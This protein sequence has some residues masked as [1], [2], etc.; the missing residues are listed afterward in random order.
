LSESFSLTAL[1]ESAILSRSASLLPAY[2]ARLSALSSR[3]PEC[4]SHH[5]QAAIN[6][7]SPSN[8][9]VS[10]RLPLSVPPAARALLLEQGGR[11][12]LWQ[13]PLQR[14]LGSYN[15]RLTAKPVWT[16]DPAV[17]GVRDS[18]LKL[19]GTAREE[20]RDTLSDD[21]AAA[22][23]ESEGLHTGDW[24]EIVILKHNVPAPSAPSSFPETLAAL[25][26]V[27]GV[28]AAKVSMVGPGTRIRPHTGPSNAR[29]RLHLTLDDGG[30]AANPPHMVVG[31]E[32]LSWVTSEVIIFDDSFEHEVV[33]EG[34]GRTRTVLIVDFWH[35]ETE[36]R[37][38]VFT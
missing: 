28:F 29:L 6:V 36:E 10:A 3:C 2:N 35:P 15:P 13:N 19:F 4:A 17:R 20:T 18:L 16:D 31:G 34:P 14:P 30:S 23:P 7:V 5:L 32:R 38:R 26:A 21:A 33:Y 11:L 37:E 1:L 24:D 9:F 12:G 8:R 22:T 27:P 25:L